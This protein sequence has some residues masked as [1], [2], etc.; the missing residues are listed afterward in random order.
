MVASVVGDTASHTSARNDAGDVNSEWKNDTSQQSHTCHVR[1]TVVVR[2]STPT[3][4]GL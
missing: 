2:K 1:T 3:G 4:Q